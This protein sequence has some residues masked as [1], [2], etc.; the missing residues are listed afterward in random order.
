MTK[1]K[2]K[3]KEFVA[4]KLRASSYRYTIDEFLSL[5]VVC[6]GEND[7]VLLRDVCDMSE[8]SYSK[9][10]MDAEDIAIRTNNSGMLSG[11]FGDFAAHEDTYLDHQEKYWARLVPGGSLLE[12]FVH[13]DNAIEYTATKLLVKNS[14]TNVYKSHVPL[15]HAIPTKAVHTWLEFVGRKFDDISRDDRNEYTPFDTYFG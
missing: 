6:S 2:Q 12:R 5:L 15:L 9:L 14:L 3:T 1:T 10:G 7:C 13:K 8:Y 11:I 4:R